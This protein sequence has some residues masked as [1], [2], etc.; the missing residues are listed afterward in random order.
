MHCALQLHCKN[1]FFVRKTP[2][3]KPDPNPGLIGLYSVMQLGALPGRSTKKNASHY[4]KTRFLEILHLGYRLYFIKDQSWYLLLD[5]NFPEVVNRS[6]NIR[7]IHASTSRGWVGCIES[8]LPWVESKQEHPSS[9]EY[10][11]LLRLNGSQHI[12]EATW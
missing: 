2:G 1:P 7:I 9:I 12:S 5:I 11:D 10:R 4:L 6:G 3:C 8:V